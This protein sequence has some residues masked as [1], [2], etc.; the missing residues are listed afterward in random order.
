MVELWAGAGLPMS[1]EL[2]RSWLD[3]MTTVSC[4]KLRE[5]LGCKRDAS[6]LK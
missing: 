6:G 2:S 5:L 4:S 1:S 3:A